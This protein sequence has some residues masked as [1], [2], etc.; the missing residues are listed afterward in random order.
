M[1]AFSQK[2]NEARSRARGTLD[3]AC[4]EMRSLLAVSG[5]VLLAA[6]AAPP[7]SGESR[8]SV[9]KTDQARQPIVGGSP[10]TTAQDATVMLSDNGQFS[11]TG[12]LIAP[13]LV[14]TARHCIATLNEE[15]GNCGTVISDGQP[16]A[17]GVS[18]GVNA[19]AAARVARGTKFYVPASK[20]MCGTDI[21]LIQLDK[22]IPNARIA[23]VR[24]TPLTVG[25]TTTAV[26]Y[27]DNGNGAD[28][29]GRYQRTGV[30]IEGIGPQSGSYRT[31]TGQ[32][33]TYTIPSG[34]F[35]TSESTCFGDSGGPLFDAQG[36][37]VGVTSRGIDDSCLDRPSIFTGLIVNQKLIED[38]AKSAG[39]PLDAANTPPS[40]PT[41]GT[42]PQNEPG[43]TDE[44]E[45]TGSKANNNDDGESTTKKPTKR[46]T[47]QVQSSGCSVPNGPTNGAGGLVYGLMLVI[48][49]ATLR[50]RRV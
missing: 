7:A 8:E 37:I 17:Q 38:A 39:H 32:T 35:S 48:V 41:D 5:L 50:R 2:P 6:C 21:A 12:T 33:L 27:G 45:E 10:S 14:L 29:P 15:Q 46:P 11:C 25:E 20:D 26:G 36:R 49:A 28:T 13:N 30:K 18:I 43:G 16:S 19:T 31:K 3:A 34:D 23:K 47:A 44:N 22:D 1:R 4:T 42:N 9:E 40:D 24:F